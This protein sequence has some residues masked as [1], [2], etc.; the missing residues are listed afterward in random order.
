MAIGDIIVGLD[1]GSTKISLVV[2][3]VNNFN[4]IEL[5]HTSEKK[6]NRNKEMQNYRW[7]RN[8]Q[9]HSR[10][11]RWNRKRNT[12]ENKFSIFNNTREICN[13]STK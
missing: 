4:Q 5:V 3:N 12:D 1:I 11:N 9:G 6:C 8:S 13:N 10:Y 7:R 2:G